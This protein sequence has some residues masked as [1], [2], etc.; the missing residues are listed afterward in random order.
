[1]YPSPGPETVISEPG[2]YK[3]YFCNRCPGLPYE[4]KPP[5]DWQIISCSEATCGGQGCCHNCYVVLVE[6]QYTGEEIEV[7]R[8]SDQLLIWVV[9]LALIM[10]LLNG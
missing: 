2:H 9:V 8:S 6:L 1:M 7:P 5:V 4:Y 3:G 10:W